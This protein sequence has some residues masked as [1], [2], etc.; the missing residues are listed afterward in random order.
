MR[1]GRIDS[2]D[3]G[4]YAAGVHSTVFTN[5]PYGFYYPG[6]PGIPGRCR[7]SGICLGDDTNTQ[8]K[9]SRLGWVSRGIREETAAHRSGL[10]TLWAM[11]SALPMFIR[12]L[13]IAPPWV[14]AVSLPFPA[15][16]FDNPWLGYP[17]GNPFPVTHEQGCGVPSSQPIS[18]FDPHSPTTSRNSWNLVVRKSNSRQT[19]WCRQLIWEI[20]ANPCVDH[21]E[22]RPGRL[23]SR[24]AMYTPGSRIQ[25]LFQYRKYKSTP[26]AR[27]A[28]S[29][30]PQY[31]HW[32]PDSI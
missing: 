30:H 21:P 5:A 22:P 13:T 27:V 26:Q 12:A 11:T 16:G 31:I 6:D 24:R 4:R 23:Y 25:S 19:G 7:A 29:K 32:N 28:L 10:L 20:R 1:D 2:F 8:W 14:V 9:K 17:G 3:E 18:P 15:G